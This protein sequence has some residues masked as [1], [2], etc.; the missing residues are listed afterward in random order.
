MVG[1]IEDSGI[2]ALFRGRSILIVDDDQFLRTRLGRAMETRGMRVYLAADYDEAMLVSQKIAIEF[3]IVDLNMPGKTGMELLKRI[4]ETTP[5]M[6]VVMV[7]GYGSIP[8]AVEAIRLGA[9]NYVTKPADADEILSSLANQHIEQPVTYKPQTLAESEW[10]HIHKVLSDCGDNISEA[11]RRLGI[12][13]R[14][15]Q[16]KL[17]KRAP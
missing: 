15:L 16:R 2:D 11:A 14:T 10:E 5:Q 3:A 4:K 12:P 13:R 7:T 17:K 6:R 8:T 9:F 1:I